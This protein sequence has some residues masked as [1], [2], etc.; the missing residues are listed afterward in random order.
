MDL[1]CFV[2]HILT[3]LSS[4]CSPLLLLVVPCVISHVLHLHP[5]LFFFPVSSLLLLLT[6][7]LFSSASLHFCCS[8][9]PAPTH[10][11]FSFSPCPHVFL[12]FILLLLTALLFSS[13]LSSL[14]A[15]TSSSSTLLFCSSFFFTCSLA[16]FFFSQHCPLFSTALFFLSSSAP[17]CSLFCICTPLL[18]LFLFCIL[19]PLSSA[20][21]LLSALLCPSY[22]HLSFF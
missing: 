6:A 4:D 7:L 17:Q 13:D 21:A 22:S 5:S 15:H 10:P 20:S 3:C 2:P 9:L 18:L 16:L 11:F 1:L 12:T 8:V 19:S 14:C